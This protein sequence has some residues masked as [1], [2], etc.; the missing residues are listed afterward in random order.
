MAD[1][2]PAASIC[3]ADG[4]APLFIPVEVRVAAPGITEDVVIGLASF[5]RNCA[6][7]ANGTLPASPS[8]FTSVAKLR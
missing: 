7:V 5:A 6:A 2:E 4:G 3:M 1:G 8:V